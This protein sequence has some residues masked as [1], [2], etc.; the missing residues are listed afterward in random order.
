MSSKSPHIGPVSILNSSDLNS[1]VWIG[2][3]NCHK[4]PPHLVFV[5]DGFVY[6]LEYE[7]SRKY[8]SPLLFKLIQQRVKP[9]IF[10]RINLD[11]KGITDSVF[12]DYDKIESQQTCLNP[13]KDILKTCGI[14][15]VEQCEYVYELIPELADKELLIDVRGHLVTTN[16][17]NN[18]FYFQIYTK[19][20][21]FDRIEKLKQT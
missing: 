7:A 12:S 4:S 19:K 11:T 5:D 18:H 14:N 17:S 13:I 3:L 15:D 9:S 21:I 10:F 8:E 2:L 16:P 20:E 6:S 1:G